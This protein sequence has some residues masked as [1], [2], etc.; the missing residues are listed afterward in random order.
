M[1]LNPQVHRVANC[2]GVRNAENRL[3]IEQAGQR[4]T[5]LLAGMSAMIRPAIM[6]SQ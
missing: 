1:S 5:T 3:A 2:C 4:E 6:S